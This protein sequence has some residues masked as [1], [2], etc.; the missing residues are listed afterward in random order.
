VVSTEVV[1]DAVKEMGAAPLEGD[2]DS[3]AGVLVVVT[4]MGTDAPLLVVTLMDC[5]A[6]AVPPS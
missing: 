5:A 1:T 3:H 6:G 4:V 2:T